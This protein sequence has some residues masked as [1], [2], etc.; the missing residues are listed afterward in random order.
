MFEMNGIIYA[1]GESPQP[2]QE[3][4][5]PVRIGKIYRYYVTEDNG[6]D[7][8]ETV[9]LNFYQIGNLFIKNNKYVASYE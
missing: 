8:R 5:K 2:A 6:R 4:K 9:S 1:V 7:L 3:G